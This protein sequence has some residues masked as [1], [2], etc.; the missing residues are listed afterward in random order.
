[1]I[2]AGAL[3]LLFVPTIFGAAS[4]HVARPRAESI[5]RGSGGSHGMPGCSPPVAWTLAY[6][7]PVPI[8]LLVFATLSALAGVGLIVAGALH[9]KGR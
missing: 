6:I 1:M 2:L 4:V 5:M 8:T 9:R 7:A 3:V